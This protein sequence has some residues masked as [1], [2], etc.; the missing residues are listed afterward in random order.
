[1][2]NYRRILIA[3][4][5]HSVHDDYRAILCPKKSD[6]LDKLIAIEDDLFS[7]IFLFPERE[8]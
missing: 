5:N 3:D 4:D 6:D 2:E 1:L 8:S 7:S